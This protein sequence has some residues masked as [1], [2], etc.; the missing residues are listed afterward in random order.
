M[1]E[2]ETSSGLDEDVAMQIDKLEAMM[3]KTLRRI[4]EIEKTGD[5]ELAD[6][7]R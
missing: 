6:D 7:M 1:S 2:T 4:K 5:P 3:L